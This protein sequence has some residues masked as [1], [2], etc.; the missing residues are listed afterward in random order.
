MD[1][2]YSNASQVL[3][4][5]GFRNPGTISRFLD[6]VDKRSRGIITRDATIPKPVVVE[7][8]QHPYFNRVWVLQEISLAKLAVLHTDYQIIHW[9]AHTVRQLMFLCK[10]LNHD[11]PGVLHW[12]PATQRDKH[13]CL[14]LLHR[15]RRCLATDPRDKVFALYSFLPAYFREALPI[16]YATGTDEVYWNIATHL[17]STTRRLDVL[18]HVSPYQPLDLE[19]MPSWVPDWEI[20]HFT[21]MEL[22][23]FTAVQMEKFAV[24][25]RCPMSMESFLHTDIQPTATRTTHE[26]HGAQLSSRHDPVLWYR[27]QGTDLHPP[28]IGKVYAVR[29]SKI[30]CLRVRA[31]LLDK[32]TTHTYKILS[33]YLNVGR[34][35]S[36]PFLYSRMCRSCAKDGKWA[37]CNEALSIRSWNYQRR[38]LSNLREVTTTLLGEKQAFETQ[39]SIGFTLFSPINES[40]GPRRARKVEPGDTIWAIEGLDV[41]V[42]LRRG[43]QDGK[44]Y[45]VLVGQCYLHR[46]GLDQ[47]CPVCGSDS[48]PWSMEYATIEIW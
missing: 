15:A 45:F 18:K 26:E 32:V 23:K 37:S 33:S 31:Y 39:Q 20:R 46:A 10:S 6:Y 35:K 17:I 38:E 2:V 43:T 8:L 48:Q 27:N 30:P 44:S 4:Y 34:I 28:V 25:F 21:H 12:L 14:D 3:L 16:N 22:P 9:D 47:E 19:L 36:T 5:L 7:F 41:P 1:A 42:I 24:F 29:N 11:P 40:P 13:N